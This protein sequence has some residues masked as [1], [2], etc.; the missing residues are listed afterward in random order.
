MEIPHE[1]WEEKQPTDIT[2]FC[3]YISQNSTL[4]Y[5]ISNPHYITVSAIYRILILTN[6]NFLL[7]HE[8]NSITTSND[9]YQLFNWLINTIKCWLELFQSSRSTMILTPYYMHD[10][11]SS[12]FDTWF[13]SSLAVMVFKA[14]WLS[15]MPHVFQC[16][17]T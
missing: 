13:P 11:F 1:S 2:E 6:S 5:K 3:L 14:P 12:F 8:G 17:E 9:T 15:S 10:G 4:F 16:P 7:Q